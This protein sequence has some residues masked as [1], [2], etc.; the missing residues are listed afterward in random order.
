MNSSFS[1]LIDHAWLKSAKIW[2]QV[3]WFTAITCVRTLIRLAVK[4][5]LDMQELTKAQFNIISQWYHAKFCQ[6]VKILKFSTNAFFFWVIF[7]RSAACIFFQLHRRTRQN[8]ETWCW[9]WSTFLQPEDSQ[10]LWS[11]QSTSKSWTSQVHPIH[12]SR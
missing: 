11:R 2:V 8:W 9:L 1:C 12:M 4:E 7:S 3:N 5:P 10:S 6:N